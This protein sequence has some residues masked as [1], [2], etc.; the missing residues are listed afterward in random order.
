MKRANKIA[1]QRAE[2]GIIW[3]MCGVR[4]RD[5]LSCVALKQSLGIDDIAIVVQQQNRF[6]WYEHVLKKDNEDLVKK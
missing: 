2:M 4:L 1:L 3:W 6:R 5:K